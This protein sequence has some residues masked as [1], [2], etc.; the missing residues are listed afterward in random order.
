MVDPQSTGIPAVLP[1]AFSST[2][3]DYLIIG[4]GT[5]ALVIAAR[6]SAISTISVGV[7]EA[8]PKGLDDQSITVPGRFGDSLGGQ[9]DWKFETVPQPG[10]NGRSLSWPRGRVLGGTSA[11]N[12]MSW[13][14]GNRED[15]DAWEELG[16]EGWGW[17]GML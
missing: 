1:S 12:F 7:L 8:G 13:T 5:A 9:Y 11:L 10:L 6:L 2:R 3:Y 17:D 4:G 14:R 16:N 15:Y